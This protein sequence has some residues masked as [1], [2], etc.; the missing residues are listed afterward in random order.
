[1][2]RYIPAHR[3]VLILGGADTTKTPAVFSHAVYKYDAEGKITQLR[4]SP[5]SIKVYINR[6]V[7]AVDPAVGTRKSAS[8]RIC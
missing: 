2:A 4:D 7:I 6:A 3:C 8:I 5:P 1:M